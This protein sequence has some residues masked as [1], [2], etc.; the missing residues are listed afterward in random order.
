MILVF[1]F[2]GQYCHLIARRIRDMGFEAQIVLPDISLEE[3]K[4]IK[5]DGIIFSGSPASV[6]A[7]DAILTDKRFLGMGIP[8]L[9][10][11]YGHKL[12][13]RLMGGIIS[14][15]RTKEYGKQQISV[16][17]KS[18]ILM[19]TPAKQVVW[20]SHGDTVESLPKGFTTIASTHGCPYAAFSDEKKNIFGVQFHPEVAHTEY[21]SA[22][23]KNFMGLTDAKKS[24]NLKDKEKEIISEI[25]KRIGSKGVIMGV[26]GGVDSLVASV[27]ISKITKNIHCVFVDHGL[28]RK[29]EA[30]YAKELYKNL[31]IDLHVE[32]ASNLFLS[33]L[34]GVTDPEL[35]RKIIGNTFIEVFDGKVSELKKKYKYIEFLGQGTIYPDR[36]E[37]AQPGGKAAVIKTHHNVGGLPAKMNLKLVEPLADLYKDE[38][39]K[40]GEL[41]GLKKEWLWRHPFPGPGLAVRILGEITTE[42]L[43]IVREA[44]FIFM[45]ELMKSGHY[46]KT[47]QAFA[48]LLPVR[49][50]GVMG[51]ERT[52]E[53]MIALRAVTSTDA[54]TA[55]W[56]RLPNELME[57]ISSRIVNE[58]RGVN[59]VV[60]DITQKPPATIE[61]E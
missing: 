28:C 7:K 13:T 10:I 52:Y 35:K 5:P 53:S 12:I 61:Y 24:W 39:R 9:G 44:D 6:I 4:K 23:L 33:K 1:N 47:W 57:K 36:I 51:D 3:V 16:K 8:V 38:V 29:N 26:S 17:S 46:Y 25:K 56:A 49:S 15:K 31:G 14:A 54:M 32:N 22:I 55:D 45:D 30:E 11:C 20:M 40:V 60:Y 18:K 21:G 58:V 59:R 27:I 42:K 43:R 37:S 34:K 41:L 2:G 50:V 48:A 19:K